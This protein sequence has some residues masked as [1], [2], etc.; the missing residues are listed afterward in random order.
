VQFK[1]FSSELRFSCLVHLNFS[2]HALYGLSADTGTTT[3][4]QI[5]F[6]CQLFAP[7]LPVSPSRKCHFPH[8]PLNSFS[9]SLKTPF[10][11]PSTRPLTKNDKLPFAH[12]ASCHVNSSQSLNQ[13]SSK[14]F[15]SSLKRDLGWSST[16]CVR[17]SAP[18]A[19]A[20]WYWTG[21]LEAMRVQRSL[22]GSQELHKKVDYSAESYWPRMPTM[23]P[24]QRLLRS[25]VRVS[26]LL[27]QRLTRILKPFLCTRSR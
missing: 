15:A 23:F 17:R 3:I 6:P 20:N 26:F 22:T 7:R 5:R 27:S 16:H 25:V 4:D 19:Y 1:R 18:S 24:F 21:G 13:C 11:L 9:K 12:S 14:S 2:L 10:P 8:F